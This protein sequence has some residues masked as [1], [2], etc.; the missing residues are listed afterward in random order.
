MNNPIFDHQKAIADNIQKSFD[1]DHGQPLL[2]G[3]DGEII[4]YDQVFSLED[5]NRFQNDL[6]KAFQ[7]NQITADELE[8]AKKDLSRLAMRQVFDKNGH[9]RVVY[10]KVH[11]DEHGKTHETDYDKGH[12]VKFHKDGKEFSGTVKSMKYHDKTD[13]VGTAMV[14]ADGKT[15]SVSLSKLKHHEDHKN[16]AEDGK[17]ES[18]KEL[19]TN[20][21]YE[22]VK[23]LIGDKTGD[24]EIK[25]AMKLS[26]KKMKTTYTES[27]YDKMVG[28]FKSI[29]KKDNDH[30]DFVDKKVKEH[31]DSDTLPLTKEKY[32][33]ADFVTNNVDGGLSVSRKE[34]G[35]KY[36]AFIKNKSEE[37]TILNDVLNSKS[38]SKA[39]LKRLFS[40]FK[41]EENDGSIADKENSTLKSKTVKIDI[42]AKYMP[43]PVKNLAG[44]ELKVLGTSEKIKS[45]GKEYF[46]KVEDKDGNTHEINRDF[47]NVDKKTNEVKRVKSDTDSKEDAEKSKPGKVLKASDYKDGDKIVYRYSDPKIKNGRQQIISGKVIDHFGDG[48]YIQLNKPLEYFDND[49]ENKNQGTYNHQSWTSKDRISSFEIYDGDNDGFAS[50]KYLSKVESSSNDNNDKDTKTISKENI[51]KLSDSELKSLKLKGTHSGDQGEYYKFKKDTSGRVVASFRY[52]KKTPSGMSKSKDG[53]YMTHASVKF[54]DSSIN[55]SVYD[56]DIE[57]AFNKLGTY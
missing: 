26:S 50:F 31:S 22:S 12:K 28:E 49:R 4:V 35:V 36:V 52:D 16:D 9:K 20:S 55:K 57:K 32:G 51:S 14:E 33:A 7:A 5:V 6:N 44:Q 29:H 19:M 23:E 37:H 41:N 47:L 39:K 11:E 21:M 3:I 8:K 42:N 15:Y 56:E 17:E 27:E 46:Y 13:K 38:V 1:T 54:N 43:I 10:V 48:I 18:S 40:N 34:N 45:S 53:I 2:K 24:K 30:K 25:N